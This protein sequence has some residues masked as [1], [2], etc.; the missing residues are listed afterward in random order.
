MK[1]HYIM[2][3]KAPQKRP[4]DIKWFG[5]CKVSP[6][7]WSM[8]FVQNADNTSLPAYSGTLGTREKCHCKR[9]VTVTISY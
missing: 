9:G 5:G 8:F 7:V 1:R 3:L 4:T 6:L 2:L